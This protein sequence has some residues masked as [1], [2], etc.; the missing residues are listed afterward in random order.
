MVLR[1][2]TSIR[3]GIILDNQSKWIIGVTCLGTMTVIALFLMR[4]FANVSLIEPLQL[5]TSGFEQESLF[6]IWKYINDKDV[7]T[8]TTDIP[9]TFSNFNWLYYVFYGSITGLMLDVLH[10]GDPW[11]PTVTRM[12]TVI[13]AVIG[14]LITYKAME[15]MARGQ[16]TDRRGFDLMA[17]G[18][19][20]LVFFGPLAGFWTLTTR[21]DIWTTAIE[22]ALILGFIRMYPTSIIKATLWA[23]A[24]GYIAWAFKTVDITV[25]GGVGIFLVW[26]RHWLAA[27]ILAVGTLS[28]WT[29]TYWLGTDAYQFSM[30][31][32]H[33]GI[34]FAVEQGFRNLANFTIKML[35]VLLPILALIWLYLRQRDLRSLIAK[36]VELQF[37]IIVGLCSLGVSVLG[38]FKVGGA[39]NYF[40]TP[41]LILALLIYKVWALANLKELISD[42]GIKL[43]GF[44]LILG[45]AVTGLAT[46]S[47]IAGVNG[48]ISQRAMHELVAQ[49]QPCLAALPQ[50]VF[51]NDMNL[52][53]PWITPSDENF[54]LSFYYHSDRDGGRVF[55]S[56]GIGGLIKDGYFASLVFEKPVA[57]FD[58]ASL[59][60][61]Q[62][63]PA[64]C[65]SWTVYHKIAP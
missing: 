22:A 28:A 9:F 29:A 20:A 15:G 27:G 56:D 63:Q 64:T 4:M 16:D 11:L 65:G 50:P 59:V 5:Q 14:T 36:D 3:W 53:L 51:V 61:Y 44:G 8:F 62:H 33:Q 23:L 55:E 34:V 24:L 57:T 26:R 47:V 2:A 38:S 54:L 49:K 1:I 41:S 32:A 35:P 18:L 37:F 13:G 43:I 52:S 60:Q 25:A 40:F 45:W 31:G 46:A 21:P 12:L 19:S 39:E 10:L 7:Y 30:L 58:G 42:K 48:V 6:S 17:L